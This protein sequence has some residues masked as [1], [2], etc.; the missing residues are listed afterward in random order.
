[1]RFEGRT[2]IITGG[3]SG[4]GAA[5]V[6]RLC[7]EGA[8]V[9]SVDLDAEAARAALGAAGAGKDRAMAEA[10]D[11]GDAEAVEALTARAV[12]RFGALD[13]VVNCAGVRGVGSITDTTRD[14]WDLN[15]RVNLTGSLNTCQ[16]F[17]R[18]ATQAGRPGA[19]V[20]ISS[21][22]GV[23]AVPNRLSYVS[24]KHGVVG[25]TRG[26]ALEMGKSGIRANC[27]APGMIYT[28]MTAPMFEDPANAARIRA[29]HPIGR[30][31]QPAEI[32][33][34]I[35]FLLSDDSSFMTGCVLPVDGGLTAGAPSF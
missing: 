1:M 12:D 16:A 17:C 30:E 10:V 33:A 13:G 6:Q 3:A 21:Q 14:V 11:I 28:P 15:L 24:A 7:D 26:V 29:A 31:G 2:Y 9:V 18:Y 4:I 20:N 32:A 5:T 27:I 34:V 25:L 22:A 8:N 35:A 19:I 23:E